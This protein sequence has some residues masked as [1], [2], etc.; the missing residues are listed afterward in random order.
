MAK[1]K[2][3]ENHRQFTWRFLAL[4]ANSEKMIQIVAESE[5]AARQQAPCGM[6]TIFVARL[7]VM[8]VAHVC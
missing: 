1:N 2:H 4:G 7:P 8:E 3:T 5:F 6:V